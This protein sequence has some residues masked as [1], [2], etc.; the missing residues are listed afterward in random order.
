VRFPFFLL[1]LLMLVASCTPRSQ[2]APTGADAAPAS[3]PVASVASSSS[4]S[5]SVPPPPPPIPL[6]VQ[7]DSKIR[8]AQA[9]FPSPPPRIRVLHDA[10]VLAGIGPGA[11]FDQAVDFVDRTLTAF[12]NHRFEALPPYAVLVYFFKRYDDY[13]G[14]VRSNFPVDPRKFYGI[15]GTYSHVA[16]VDGSG[17]LPFLPTLSHELVHPILDGELGTKCPEFASE[18]FGSLFEAP[19]FPAPGEI[20]GTPNWRFAKVL[21]PALH[22]RDGGAPASVSLP[23]LF[24]MDDDAFLGR[25]PGGDGDGDGDG[26]GDGGV[27]EHAQALHYALARSLCLFLDQQGKL[28]PWLAAWR[29]H[30][31]TDPTGEAAFTSAMGETPSQVDEAWRRWVD[32]L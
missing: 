9:A 18:C 20:R 2:S 25:R 24:H 27:D 14:Y 13:A 5:S 3:A 17:G 8:E 28:W 6:P 21:H 10:F 7:V 29:G 23:A 4:S 31:D 19:T 16:A 11:Y 15:Y 12:Y 22:P 32:S 1:L 26:G 30:L